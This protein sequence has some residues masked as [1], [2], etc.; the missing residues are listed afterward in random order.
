MN[1]LSFSD[2]NSILKL[3]VN[4]I[5]D[6]SQLDPIIRIKRDE[7]KVASL[8]IMLT[9]L[10]S[11]VTLDFKQL[12]SFA[13]ALIEPVHLTQGP[14]GT[15]KSYLGVVIVRA[16]LIIRK[17]WISVD[18]TV[19]KPPILVLSYKNHAIDEFLSDL[20][21]AERDVDLIRIGDSLD[22]VLNRY[23]ER[24]FRSMDSEVK[25]IKNDLNFLL[26][27]KEDLQLK[28]TKLSPMFAYEACIHSQL[29]DENEVKAKKIASYNA[30]KFLHDLIVQNKK[31]SDFLNSQT[32]ENLVDLNFI[33][34]ELMGSQKSSLTVSDIQNIW[35]GIKHYDEKLDLCEVILKWIE[36]VEPLP[37]CS[38]NN[39]D[40][41][42]IVCAKGFLLCHEHKCKF[43][44][45]KL[46]H[47]ESHFLCEEHACHSTD[48]KLVKLPSPQIFCKEHACFICL[49]EN[50]QAKISTDIPPRNTCLDH[51][52]CIFVEK[53]D[54]CMNLASLNTSYCEDHKNNICSSKDCKKFALSRS[55]PYCE[56]HKPQQVPLSQK[57]L[58]C[59]AK[60]KKKKQC[61]AICKPGYEYCESHA[62]L[63]KASPIIEPVTEMNNQLNKT[64][65]KDEITEEENYGLETV[66]KTNNHPLHNKPFSNLNETK[67]AGKKCIAKNKKK[68]KC[69]SICKPGY[70]YCEIH[71]KLYKASP[72]IEP[73]TEMNN[74]SNKTDS[75]KEITQENNHGLE[76]VDKLNLKVIGPN[77]TLTAVNGP[78][79]TTTTSFDQ[80]LTEK[81][82]S[83][84]ITISNDNIV[85][86]E[87]HRHEEPLPD[88]L[89]DKI[90][91]EEFIE[92]SDNLQHMQEVYGFEELDDEELNAEELNAEECEREDIS[93]TSS[94]ESIKV[95]VLSAMLPPDKWTW[96]MSLEDRW[97][98]CKL[99][100]KTFNSSLSKLN[101]LQNLKIKVLRKNH[102]EAK[103]KAKTRVY[104]GKSV[105]G[106]TIVGC[107]ARLEAIRNTK[108]FAILVEEASEVLEPLVFSCL[109]DTTCKLE[110]IGDHLQLKPSVMS[111]I[112]FER[113]NK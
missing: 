60:N 5:I 103:I 1:E 85:N 37:K 84:D 31:L 72:I 97:Y 11:D 29:Q 55:E 74:Q 75:K 92:E 100:E 54:T 91:Q 34:N 45:C 101:E 39:S 40:C 64:G 110:M 79:I 22:S 44:Q 33:W 93:Q 63:Y 57:I 59:T 6:R 77:E 108:P 26:K 62:K 69:K 28:Q 68:K 47:L 8:Q 98:Q 46:V 42:N 106:G 3:L 88:E 2:Y 38:F 49:K 21:K 102:H 20:V 73:V 12:R 52:L 48:C 81:K 23:S 89:L 107:I 36:G 19:G 10:V 24:N 76:T 30:A 104:E 18:P 15:G 113:R 25:D 78:L 70:E 4:L 80:A 43:Q 99:L 66:D 111:K 56:N 105:I 58:H 7:M 41:R 13:E 65:P 109:A 17:I 86:V 67:Q 51:Q 32:D 27:Q 95:K 9:K 71:A 82:Y 90:D 16:L 50:S 87:E 83:A 61:K 112:M 14:P 35:D 53:N 96:E 94:E